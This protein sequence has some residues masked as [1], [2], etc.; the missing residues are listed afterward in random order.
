MLGEYCPIQGPWHNDRDT[1]FIP[2]QEYTLRLLVKV[3][4]QRGNPTSFL[5]NHTLETWEKTNG[6]DYIIV[7]T[8]SYLEITKIIHNEDFQGRLSGILL[9]Q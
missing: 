9:A 1:I 4:E 7:S 6:R 8:K 5:E 2:F 3:V